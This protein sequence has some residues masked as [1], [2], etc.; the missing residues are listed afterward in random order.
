MNGKLKNYIYLLFSVILAAA[1]GYW[2]FDS[3]G[4]FVLFSAILFVWALLVIVS[5]FSLIT[6]FRFPKR[7][8]IIRESEPAVYKKLGVRAFK[9]LIR[10]GPIHVLAPKIQINNTGDSF[11]QLEREMRQ[12]ET[13][14][15]A[16]MLIS[17]APAAT[18]VM[19]GKAAG[20]ILLTV[21]S[22]ALHAYPVML[23]R[24][25]RGRINGITKTG[26][27]GN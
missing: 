21:L 8:Y 18:A 27:E 11:G 24:Y 16:A 3:S 20:G 19:I 17:L 13:I 14:H 2:F 10:R 9:K 26:G 4:V 7:Y 15:A 5:V 12:A 6:G 22:L 25:N 1:A 23:Q